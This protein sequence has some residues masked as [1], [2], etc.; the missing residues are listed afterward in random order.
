MA[1]QQLLPD[2]YQWTDCCNVYVFKHGGSALLVDLGDG[3]VLDHLGELGVSVVEWVLFTHHHREQCLGYPKLKAWKAKIAAPD[4]ERALFEKP[5]SF[6]K[7]APALGDQFTVYG[8]SYARPPLQPIPLDR[9][10][11]TMDEFEW[12]G[13]RFWCVDTRGNSPGSMSYLFQRD[14]RFAALTGDLMLDGAKL[15]NWFDSEWDYG[16]GAAIHALHAGASLI[17]RFAPSLLL[18][19]HGKIVK[20]P[21]GQLRDYQNKLREL[22]RLY[23][24][25]YEVN[26]FGGAAQDNVSRPTAVPHVWQVTPHIFKFKGPNYWP[27]FYLILSQAGRGLCVDCGLFDKAFLDDR[28]AQMQQF[29]GLKQIDAVIITHMH[30]DHFLEAPHLREK[31]GAQVWTLDRVADK[32]QFPERYDYVAAGP[33]YGTGLKTIAFDRVFRAGEKLRW[34]EY[35]LTVDWMP[36]QTEFGLCVQGV[37]D[38]QRV[39]FTGDNIF[40]DPDDPAQ[41]GHE[42][43]VAHNSAVLEEGYIYAAEYLKRL[44]PDLLLGGHSWVMGRPKKMI[45]RY[46]ECARKLRDAFKGLSAEDDYRYMFDPFWVRAEPYRLTC[47]PGGAAECVVHVRNFRDRE[48]KHRIVVRTPEGVAAQ[49]E[50]LEGTVA[51]RSIGSFPLKLSVDAS[52]PRGVRIATFD[53]ELDGRRYGEW[54]D[55]IVNVEA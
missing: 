19:S 47:K 17:E 31:W 45:E 46:G 6:R 30:G 21:A 20:E 36:G 38:G 29:L 11:K 3:S 39:A 18:P 51:A 26:T 40:G 42:A 53:V 24:R 54:F 50:V 9:T 48:Q 28:I 5:A 2:L 37:I 22:C 25:G 44:K 34:Q 32:C 15:H 43:V 49:P 35:D 10:F 1:F 33:Y 41:N 4:A 8:S 13:I 12:N 55:V 14:G 7:M 23:L 52:A 16:F 27:N